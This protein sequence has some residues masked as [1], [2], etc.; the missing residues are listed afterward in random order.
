MKGEKKAMTIKP[1]SP[2]TLYR[3]CDPGE[4]S[5]ATTAD[6]EDLAEVI[7]Q[8]RAVSSIEFGVGIRHDGYNLYALG[9]PGTGK[10]AVVRDFLERKAAA[11]PLPPDWCYVNNFTTPHKPR[12]LRLA[13]GHGEVLRRRM[14]Q[15]VEDLRSVIPATFE[16]EDYRTRMHVVEEEL[17]ERQEKAFGAVQETAESKGIA[18]IRT[19]S[20]FAFAPTRKGEV[21]GPDEFEKLPEAERRR[22]EED[23]Q[24]LQEAL[25][26]TLHQVPQWRRETR[27]KVK[28]L[29]REVASFAVG[30]LIGELRK[31]YEAAANVVEF[32]NA[33]EQDVIEHV[34]DFR[35]TEEAP[36]TLFGVPLPQMLAESPSFHRYRVNV[37][38]D[39]SNNG[40]A[41]VVYE[42]NPNY[43]NMMGRIEHQAQ[44]GALLTDFTMIKPGAL[45]R[46]NGGYLMLDAYKVLTQPFVW[47]GLKRAL[48]S[49]EIRMESLAQALSL[50]STVSLEPEPIPLEVKVVLVGERMLYYLLAFYDPEFGEHFKVAA[51]FDEQMTRSAEN[52]Q[53]YARLVATIVRHEKL[54]HFAPDAV[55]RVIEHSARI[56]GDAERLST[57]TRSIV[58]LLREADYWC[59]EAR[60]EVV[61]AADVQRAI[62]AQIHRVSRLRERI[63]EEIRRGTMLIDT[64]G[65]VAGQVNGLTVIGLGDY[66]FGTPTRITA[67]VRLGEGEVMDIEREVE[68]GGPIHSKGVLIL[69][70]FLGARFAKD[71]PLSLAASLVFEQ[72]Y[73]EVEGDS[74]SSAE[75]YALLSALADVPIK[76]SFA[77]TG[78]VNQHGQ[79]QPIGGVNEKI[80]GFFE[81]CRDRGLSGAQ[82]VL[83]PASNVKHLMLRRDVVEAVTA[84]K[85]HVYAVETIDQGIE[86]LTG[87]PAGARDASGNFPEGSVNRRVEDRLV[88]MAEIRQ[89]FGAG[90]KGDG[91]G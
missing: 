54:R 37:L 20:G 35:R 57:H 67:R 60:R 12:A 47:E 9:P 65:A 34:D 66:S 53:L 84:G 52:N 56:V 55:A 36:P 17:K 15:L 74:A 88:A 8:A 61:R 4:F 50:V 45:H 41:P 39:H 63:Q 29:N 87:V 31:E 7:G 82:G 21:L 89:A 77:V 3:R 76:Q 62:D 49:R 24:Q 2:D 6:L 71:R 51:D 73:G 32:L 40:G 69:G 68:L 58:D 90:P 11:R 22:V 70:G 83:V 91:Q 10:R 16:S 64:D 42:D 26:R 27:D 14:E 33:V 23:V 46:A 85:F 13:P 59:G 5:F 1:L 30:H 80:E 75:L 81:V 79:I 44:M 48:R 43:N 78:S 28:E 18:L 38:V 19:P 25:Q 72:T 86:I